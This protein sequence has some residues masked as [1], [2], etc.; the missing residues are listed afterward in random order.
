[1]TDT[2][3]IEDC[4]L[5]GYNEATGCPET[6]VRNYHCSLSNNPE[7]RSSTWR[8]Q[9]TVTLTTTTECWPTKL[10]EKDCFEATP[11]DRRKMLK[12]LWIHPPYGGDQQG[13]AVSR[14]GPR[15]L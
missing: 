9:P 1:M 4:D 11:V 3:T 14:V 8:R 6:S 15:V 10:N 7:E 13:T 2:T 12:A 5:L